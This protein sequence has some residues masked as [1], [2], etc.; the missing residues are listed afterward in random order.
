MYHTETDLS[1]LL[2]FAHLETQILGMN[3]EITFLCKYF[4]INLH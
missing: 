1:P 4:L 3:F 2:T